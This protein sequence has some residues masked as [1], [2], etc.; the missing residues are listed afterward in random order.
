M[1][2]DGSKWLA[3]SVD[4]EPNKDGT[5]TGIEKAMA[6]FDETV[7]RGTVYTTYRIATELPDVVAALAVDNEIGVHVHPREFGHDH[8]QLAELSTDRQRGL[9]RRTRAA[10]AEAA[11]MRSDDIVSFRAGRHSASEAT[12]AV[13][14]DL[15]FTVDASINVRYTEYLP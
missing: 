11:S 12:F 2:K 7:P 10:V 4:L 1:T 6:W 13:L 5:L 9:I 8:D 14:A 3:F 15:G